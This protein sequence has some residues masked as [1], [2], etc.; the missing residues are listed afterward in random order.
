MHRILTIGSLLNWVGI[1]CA[2]Q[3]HCL[4]LCQRIQFICGNEAQILMAASQFN[5]SLHPEQQ[6]V[7]AS[8]NQYLFANDD[9]YNGTAVEA[10]SEDGEGM[11]DYMVV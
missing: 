4:K 10:G 8:L 7:Q 2:T 9:P 1:K 11:G 6:E 3:E 5:S